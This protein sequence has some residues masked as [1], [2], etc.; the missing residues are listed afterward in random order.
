MKKRL[1]SSFC[2]IVMAAFGL[3][4]LVAARPVR[5]AV[6][7]I[8]QPDNLAAFG[9]AAPDTVY[10]FVKSSQALNVFYPGDPVVVTLKVAPSAAAVQSLT[11]KVVEIG[12]RHDDYLP[13][14]SQMTPPPKYDNLGLCGQ[15][16]QP[17]TIGTTPEGTEITSA[18][19]PVPSRYGTYLIEVAP[20]GKNPQFLCT[21]VRV[22]VPGPGFDVDMPIMADGAQ[23]FG[24][25]RKGQALEEGAAAYERLGFKVLRVEDG[26]RESPDGV[27][28]WSQS[29]D[30]MN[31]LAA[32]HIK[33]NV[34]VGAEPQWSMPYG[35]RPGWDMSCAPTPQM[36]ARFGKWVKALCER[37]WKDGN[38]AIW[39]LENWNEPWEPRGISGWGA[40]SRQYREIMKQI[41]I[42]ARA[43]DPRIKTAA[44]CSI[45]NTEDKFL[46]GDNP[47]NEIQYVDYFTDHYVGPSNCYGPMVAAFWGKQSYETETWGAANELLIPQFVCTFLGDGQ[48]RVS[49][50]DSEMAF[51][52]VPGS[53]VHYQMPNPL[54][55][56]TNAA[57]VMIGSR[58]FKRML[59]LTHLPMAYQFGEDNDAVVI[60]L[61]RLRN[62]G[63]KADLLA[64]RGFLWSQYQSQ[65]GG[66]LTIDNKDGALRFFDVD[67]NPEF[68]GQK[69]VTIPMD[70]MGHYITAPK[71]GATLI[72]SRLNSAT[73]EGAR[74]VEIISHD[75]TTPLDDPKCM[76]RVTLHNLLDTPFSGALT[77]TAPK[78]ITLAQTQVA[79]EIPTGATMDFTI[80]VL[81]AQPDPSNAYA[82]HFSVTGGHEEAEWD[83]TLSV[84]VIRRGTKK[85]DGNMADWKDDY[86]VLLSSTLQKVDPLL[87]AWLPFD[88]LKDTEPNGS[89]GQVKMAWDDQNLYLAAQV[90][91]DNPPAPHIRRATWNQDSYFFGAADDALC[92]ALRP[93]RSVV[94]ANM[95]DPKIAAA[96]NANP[97]YRGICKSL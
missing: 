68:V 30:L 2:T 6:P 3:S 52:D 15:V 21:V 79:V 16:A 89:V 77:V 34:T 28:D 75:F 41:A 49:P 63:Y 17:V 20:D 33:L 4:L 47:A 9:C 58:P 80:P 76:L 11:F 36:Y 97:L 18:A 65:L 66:T 55:T 78:T 26:W 81:K 14:F 62:Y 61:N 60:L 85:L 46:T 42:N 90:T 27:Y 13:G 67:G 5:A 29:D 88:N 7:D 39:V 86:P 38:G 82:F 40:D 23:F 12:T 59:S 70:W 91:S 43:V 54:V 48:R 64:T 74:P 25:R 71:G 24:A 87:R 31:T 73:I 83:E 56:A 84:L 10:E 93:Y 35:L 94:G 50:W 45:M 53:P 44:A 19:L 51:F 92:E 69:S 1:P 37:Y 96:M 72:A 22:H 8:L 95:R 32:H 57:N